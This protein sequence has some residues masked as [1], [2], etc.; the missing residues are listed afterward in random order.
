MA[1][2]KLL[3]IFSVV[4][5]VGGMFFAY[6]VLRPSIGQLLKLPE[7]IR[8]WDRVLGRF[9]RWVWLAVFMLLLSGFYLIYLFG[10]MAGMPPFIH[11]MM[12]G[13]IVMM[14]IFAYVFFGCYVRFNM[15][16][17]EKEWHQAE[18]VLVT[19]RKLVAT[20]LVLGLMTI[21]IEVAGKG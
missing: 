2:F 3:H 4:V 17:A 12:G 21:A 1:I 14:L 13:G 15:L 18:E 20:N 11:L 16:A 7:R 19:I 9:F 5:W 6:M 10:G 8:L